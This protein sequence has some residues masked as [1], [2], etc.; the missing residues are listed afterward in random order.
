MKELPFD[1][2]TLK[3]VG[4]AK[5]EPDADCIIY[6]PASKRVFTFN[7][8]SHTATAIDPSTGNNVG[9]IDLGAGPEF[10]V[11]DGRGTIYNNLEDKNA[12]LTI[13]SRSLKVKSHGRSPPQERQRRSRW[14]EIIDGCSL[15]AGN[16]Q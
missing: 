6:D 15:L 9:T 8:D 4:E 12:V 1:L 2:K 11:A 3:V 5:A 16:R 7:G 13:D 14:I 10:A